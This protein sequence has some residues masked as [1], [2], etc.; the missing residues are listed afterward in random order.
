MLTLFR[1]ALF[2]SS[3]ALMVLAVLM[4]PCLLLALAR[5]S[6]TVGGWLLAQ[7]LTLL[8][9]GGLWSSCRAPVAVVAPRQMCLITALS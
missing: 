5:E 6:V 8:C 7:I 4:L 1:P 2:V 3:V 9:G